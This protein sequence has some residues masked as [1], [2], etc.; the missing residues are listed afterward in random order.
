M[1]LEL[2]KIVNNDHEDYLTAVVIPMIAYL[3]LSE[4][5]ADQPK[6]DAKLPDHWN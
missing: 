1:N 3:H 6:A 4:Y 2:E 5:W